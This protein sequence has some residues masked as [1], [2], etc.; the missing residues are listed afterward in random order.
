MKKSP[1]PYKNK[2][3][4]GRIKM[5]VEIEFLAIREEKLEQ[6]NDWCNSLKITL[7]SGHPQE[8]DY[9]LFKNGETAF[10]LAHGSEDGFIQLK[11]K[12]YKP[13]QVVQAFAPIAK[14][15][16]ISTIYSLCC[17]GGVQPTVEAE[18]VTLTSFHPSR[19]E[20][21]VLPL[22]ENISFMFDVTEEEFM[23]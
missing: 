10:V 9:V 4:K 21:E 12:L 1:L 11:N 5:R 15:Q 6:I 7:M 19:K 16:G 2:K 14:K 13:E 3:K 20:V 22:M 8:K 18:G 17:Y 23:N